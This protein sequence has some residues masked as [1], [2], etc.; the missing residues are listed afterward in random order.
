MP[1]MGWRDHQ[2]QA[3]QRSG[4][5]AAHIRIE[6]Y[7]EILVGT[8]SQ[9]LRLVLHKMDGLMQGEMNKDK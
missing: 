8:K 2:A 5:H 9:Q 3:A 1:E 4:D 6:I 7:T